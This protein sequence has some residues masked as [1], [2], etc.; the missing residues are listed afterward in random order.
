MEL[1][2]QE[3]LE[4][5]KRITFVEENKNSNIT[6][7]EINVATQ[8]YKNNNILKNKIYDKNIHSNFNKEV[9][10][11]LDFEELKKLKRGDI[12]WVDLRTNVGSEQRSDE[13]GRPVVIIQNDIGNAFAPTII[14]AC[15][16]SQM[17]PKLPTHVQ[18]PS[19]K[20]GL[21]K[22]SVVLA[23]QI[24]TLD[25]KKRVLRKTGTLSEII[26]S[27]IDKALVVSIFPTRQKTPLEK[28]PQNVKNEI[29]NRLKSIRTLE[30]TINTMYVNKID[31]GSINLIE[32]RMDEALDGL[33]YYCKINNIEFNQIYEESVEVNELLAL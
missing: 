25:K 32:H 12:V 26:M 17:K 20:N 31:N 30:L 1:T 3:Q 2:L 19:D 15:I 16:T 27:K 8:D 9:A 13:N 28:L 11:G 23:E 33:K 21:S 5:F 4:V 14:T 7:I 10:R 29:V 6:K 24:M 18:V 22:D